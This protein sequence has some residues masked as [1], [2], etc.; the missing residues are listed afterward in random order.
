MY[1]LYLYDRSQVRADL[2]MRTYMEEGDN[3]NVLKLL[4]KEGKKEN[5]L[6]QQVYVHMYMYVYTYV[7]LHMY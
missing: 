1:Y 2:V 3:A 4:K 5:S 6:G 7:L